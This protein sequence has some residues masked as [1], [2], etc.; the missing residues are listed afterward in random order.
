MAR[1][2]IFTTN[3]L[4]EYCMM[5]TKLGNT[6][7]GNKQVD[8]TNVKTNKLKSTF[9]FLLLFPRLSERFL[10]NTQMVKIFK[11]LENIN[12]IKINDQSPLNETN[13]LV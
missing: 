2:G 3:I 8:I 9:L 5:P 4:H 7:Q 12:H 11:M 10:I 6:N 1:I 13:E